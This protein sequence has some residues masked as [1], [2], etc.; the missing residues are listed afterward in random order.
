M[1]RDRFPVVIQITFAILLTLASVAQR[2]AHA[3]PSNKPL[4]TGRLVADGPIDAAADNGGT[5]YLGGRFNRFGISSGPFVTV[6]AFGGGP[7]PQAA[8]LRAG[9]ANVVIPDGSGGWYV[10]GFELRTDDANPFPEVLHFLSDGSKDPAFAGPDIVGVVLDLA[11]DNARLYIAGDF[12]SV[13]G[14][15]KR[16]LVAVDAATGAPESFDA[17]LDGAVYTVEKSAS[18]LYVGGNFTAAGGS[19]RASLAA[20]DLASQTLTSWNPGVTGEVRAMQL[21]TLSLYVGG[22]FTVAGGAARQNLAELNTTINTN[23]ATL[24]NPQPNDTV[25]AIAATGNM[26]IV[27]GEF[28]L[29][30]GN[31]RYFLAAFVTSTGGL[32]PW[33]PNPTG[34][35]RALKPSAGAAS[36]YVGGDFEAIAGSARAFAAEVSLV[37][38]TLTLWNPGP[39]A[40]VRS[41]ALEQ[42]A[43]ALVG[44]FGGIGAQ[45]RGGLA[46]IDLTTHQLTPWTAS[47]TGGSVRALAIGPGDIIYIGGGFGAINMTPRLGLAALHTDGTVEAWNPGTDGPVNTLA[48]LSERVFVGGAFAHAG[49]IAATN[50]VALHPDTGAP[51]A[52]AIDASGEVH[53]LV[54]A[55]DGRLYV[56]GA[57]STVAGVARANIAALETSAASVTVSTWAPATNGVVY[58]IFDTGTVYIGGSFSQV[59]GEP[60]DNLAALN[61][62]DG[63][64]KTGFVATTNGPVR[65]LAGIR[66][67]LFIGGQFTA[68]NGAQ[69][70]GLANVDWTSGQLRSW[71]AR[72]DQT[73]YPTRF[74]PRGMGTTGLF[75]LGTYDSIS[76][77]ALQGLS[78]FPDQAP[79]LAVIPNTSVPEDQSTSVTLN[80][81]DELLPPSAFHFSVFS[82]DHAI[83]DNAGL[84]LSFNANTWTLT[85]TPKPNATGP[86]AITVV[87]DD[88]LLISP[89][90]QFVLSVTPVNDSPPVITGLSDGTILKD[91][92]F[93]QAFT[94]TDEDS[95]PID[96]NLNKSSSNQA[97]VPD[98]NV[99][100]SGANNKTV[101]VT[102]LA[103]QTGTTVI[104]ISVND[105]I[106]QAQAAFTVTVVAGNAAPTITPIANQTTTVDV[107]V[108]PL[109]F[110]VNDVDGGTLNVATTSSNLTLV[111]QA[112]IALGGGESNRTVTVTPA[113]GQ[114]G[115]ATITLTVTDA[116]N[117]TAS[118]SFQVLVNGLPPGPPQNLQATVV[119]TQATLTWQAPVTGGP[120]TM[121]AIE[122]GT[123]PGGSDLPTTP[124]GLVTSYVASL[125]VG[126]YY[127]R[128]RAANEFGLSTP[129]NEISVVIQSGLPSLPG[130]PTG[131]VSGVAAGFVVL[132]WLP[133]ANGGQP[134]HYVIEAG[135]G[136]GQADLGSV[137]TQTTATGVQIQGVPNGVYYVRIRAANAQ[138][139]GPASNE[140]VVTVGPAADCVAAPTP[141]V[142][143]TPTVQGSVVTLSWAPGA[144]D[145]PSGY[146]IRVGTAPGQVDIGEIPIDSVGTSLMASAP[147][148]T[149]YLHMV[150][151]NACGA[152]PPSNEVS[153]T[154]NTAPAPPGPVTGL[155]WSLGPNNTVTLQWQPAGGDVTSYLVIAGGSPGAVDLAVVPT[156]TTATSLSVSGVGPGTYY[157]YVRA[158]NG[159]G[160]GPPSNGIAIVVPDPKVRLKADPTPADPAPKATRDLARVR[161][162]C[163]GPLVLRGVRCSCVGSGFSRTFIYIVLSEDSD[164]RAG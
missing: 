13:N 135:S 74:V 103:G 8:P 45:L 54:D 120:P 34:H 149:Y 145:A 157:V 93:T 55:D 1:S 15:A 79:T 108:G 2:S 151:V 139:V 161:S 94:V 43:I 85:M 119:N 80:A 76:F 147:P 51:V 162:S 102:P 82:S 9:I 126:T 160:H 111:P 118:T 18:T 69:R 131:L 65:A 136:W 129:S 78:F 114:A 127:L 110:S 98:A 72:I 150:A 40:S 90:R 63:S 49:G 100:V 146:R 62:S 47:V 57:F 124:V 70:F 25:L 97:L 141:P 125:P 96:F 68:V 81:T 159:G 5:L 138:G 99:V 66:F 122:G 52:P 158:T 153:L 105:G 156:G 84:A 39:M 59:N 29:I 163:A 67:G 36:V 117:A 37:D 142:G 77:E 154:V 164:E 3:E 31:Q 112:G 46:A 21:E 140:A 6:S 7:L 148:G 101:S 56:G 83:V 22:T 152:S 123:T 44:V 121:Y 92:V 10:G 143:L 134:T 50:L 12:V 71:T 86:T 26:L 107:A 19:G 109:S 33:A 23:N 41:I 64:L 137:P 133:P 28:S 128:L 130:A 116:L 73:R 32:T 27:G 16:S 38:G 61:E 88:G 91:T 11:L 42:P 24:W 48:V 53:S 87:M 58:T 14:V 106:N 95:D 89:V 155:T 104:L 132:Y 17:G 20:F 115:V 60:R 35:V 113:A 75:V 144:G 4:V 30:S